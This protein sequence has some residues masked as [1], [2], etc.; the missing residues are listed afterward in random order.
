MIAY[1]EGTIRSVSLDTCVVFVSGIGYRVYY[2]GCSPSVGEMVSWHVYDHI[3]EDRRELFGAPDAQTLDLFENL[4][5]INGVG[6]RLAQKIL[7][8]STSTQVQDRIL[9]EDV[10]FL[11]T[12][13][14]VGK[15]TAQKIVLEL[16]GVLVKEQA[17]SERGDTDT[18]EALV[19]LGYSRRD[20]MEVAKQVEGETIEE[21]I[22]H[23][24]KMFSN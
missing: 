3:R 11:T 15:K 5:D 24:L 7:N 8:F 6:P 17:E 1:L 19:S 4:I 16:K 12:I 14:G 9:K 23:A 2:M 10:A 20:A 21:K 18:I 22:K 13:P